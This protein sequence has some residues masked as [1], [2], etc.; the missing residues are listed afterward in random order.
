MAGV[1]RKEKDFFYNFFHCV[2]TKQ[3]VP[4][5]KDFNGHVFVSVEL[6]LKARNSSTA[7]SAS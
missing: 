3:L 2:L 6:L 4:L 1:F 7:I 5:H